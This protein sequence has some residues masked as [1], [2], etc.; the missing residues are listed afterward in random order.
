[1]TPGRKGN[2]IGVFGGCLIAVGVFLLLVIWGAMKGSSPPAT[3]TY[4]ET[5]PIMAP[6]AAPESEPA[7]SVDA[8]SD[9]V[10]SNETEQDVVD[11]QSDMVHATETG[12]CYHQ[13]GCRSLS[14]SDIPMSRAEA[15]A[16]GL[17][18][19]SLCNP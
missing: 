8:S 4:L 19:C 16:R 5:P 13:A 15:Q 7:P 2:E 12:A 11:T 18:A 1:M 17:T 14:K 9:K 3:E 6:A 10:G